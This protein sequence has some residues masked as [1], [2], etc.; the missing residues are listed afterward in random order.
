MKSSNFPQPAPMDRDFA[1]S[2]CKEI[3]TI[4]HQSPKWL[5]PAL[6]PRP[7]TV[8]LRNKATAPLRA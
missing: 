3:P 6:S 5:T 8:F 4:D 1:N 2:T 7:W